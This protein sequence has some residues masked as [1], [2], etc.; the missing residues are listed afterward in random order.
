MAVVDGN[1]GT[2][3]GLVRRLQQIPGISV[4]GDAADLDGALGM[5]S[6][7][8]P[9]VV[10]MDL[11]RIAPD[12]A[13]ALS[14]LAGVAPRMGIVILTAYVTE[15]ERAD[16]TRAGA[17]AILLKEIDSQALARTIRAVAGPDR[18]ATP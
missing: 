1:P 8:R 6:E 12:G 14:R 4:V 17:R 18:G 9:D 2:R 7:R 13:E 16:L 3:H 11:R 10:V 15:R 5:V